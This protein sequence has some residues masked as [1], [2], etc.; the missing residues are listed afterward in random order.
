[1]AKYDPVTAFLHS[2]PAEEAR[3]ELRFGDLDR[4]VGGLPTSARTYR[5]WWGNSSHVQ[6]RAWRAAGWHVQEVDLA[7]GRVVF[8]R[9]T[10]GGSYAQRLAAECSDPV[11][12][13]PGAEAEM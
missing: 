3:I 11:A 8:A 9:G 5:P 2:V 13:P 7:Q 4:L 1:M 10:I 6:A 12:G